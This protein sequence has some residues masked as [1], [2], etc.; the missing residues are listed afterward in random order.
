MNNNQVY[1]IKGEELAAKY[2]KKHGYKIIKRNYKCPVGEI[3]I[4]AKD[5][6]ILV[7]IEV[8]SRNSLAYGRPA[9]AVDEFKQRKL[10]QLAKYYINLN[11]LYNVFARFDV[12]E[13]L[14]DE[15]NLIQNAWTL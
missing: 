8:K 9:E 2:L 10:T 6:D 1:G 12:V 11:N 5:K 13:V 4:I 14:G 3:D 15:I 7:F